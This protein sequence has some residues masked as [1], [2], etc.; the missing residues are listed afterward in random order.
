MEDLSREL[1]ELKEATREFVVR[2]VEPIAQK[3]HLKGD[4]IPDDLLRKM[5]DMGFFRLMASPEWGGLGMGA[6]AMTVVT[7]ELCRG[8]FS[9]G[10]LP[11]RNW[12]TANALEKFGTEAQ[13]KKW[14]PGI[15]SGEIQAAH[16]CTEPEAGSDAAALKTSATLGNGVYRVTGTKQWCTQA[17][18]ADVLKVFCRT[19]ASSKRHGGISMLLCEKPRGEQFVPPTLTGQRIDTIGYHGMHTYSLFFDGHEIPEENLLGGVEGQGFRHLM[20]GYELAR[21]R[22]AFSCIGL[23]RA[24]FEAA[25]QYSRDRVQFGQPIC[26]FQAIRGKLADMATHIEAARQLGYACARKLDAGLR[27]DQEAGMLKLFASEMAQMVCREAVQIH[28]GNGFATDMPVNRYWRDSCLLTI[29]EGTSEIQREV[30]ARRL[31][32]ER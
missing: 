16:A 30:I 4:E 28:G 10:A 13:K 19:G 11:S 7:E 21:T 17:N 2:E 1:Q 26:N 15:V 23:A 27:V 20:V 5:I 14:L 25:L 22:F 31:L 24:A 29:G 9:V 8:W 3:L 6:V 18:R 12:G 32:G